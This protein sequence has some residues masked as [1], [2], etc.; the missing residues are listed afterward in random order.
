MRA[1]IS[2]LIDCPSSARWIVETETLDKTDN[3]WR[4]N[5]ATSIRK[6]SSL[7]WPPLNEIL[8]MASVAYKELY[9]NLCFVVPFLNNQNK[10]R[11]LKIILSN[12]YTCID[13]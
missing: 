5:F 8:L 10:S 1:I 6:S 9:D 2:L 3:S 11:L 12:V 4:V 13:R 7:I